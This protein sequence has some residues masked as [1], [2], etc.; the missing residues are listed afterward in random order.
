MDASAAEASA[1]SE[2]Q[3]DS[4]MSSQ[5]TDGSKPKKASLKRSKQ[6]KEKKQ[7]RARLS[8]PAYTV[9]QGEDM[10][11]VIS[12]S[13]S[14]Y[15]GS[16]WT[17]KKKG[18]KKKKIA[19]GKL[20]GNKTRP[21]KMIRAK[22]VVENKPDVPKQIATADSDHSWGQHLPEEVLINIFQLVVLQDGAVPFLCRVGRVCRLWN[23]AASSPVLWRRVT[24][25]HCWIAPGKSQ[26][27]NTERKVKQTVEWLAQNRFHQLRDF[28]L[29]HWTSHVD[30]TL[31]VV[32]K[33][34]P[35]LRSLKLSY[36][37]GLTSEA[38]QSLGQHS[39]QL[40]SLDLQYSEFKTEGLVEYLETHGSQIKQMLLTHELKN[41]K[42][43]TTIS[44]GCCPDLELLEVS[45]KLDSKDCDLPICI[46]ALQTACPKLKTFRMLN[47]RPMNKT[48]GATSSLSGFPLLEE[49]SMA[50]TSYSYV[51]DKFLWDMLSSS[52]HLR[53]LDLRGCARITPH[54]L[55]VLPCPELECLFW[56]Q[57]FSRHIGSSLPKKGLH[58]VTQKWSKTLRELD[59]ANQLFTEEDLD[60]AMSYL[61]QAADA[62]TLRSLNLSGTSITQP[63]I[64]SIVGEMTSLDYLNL[65]S[66]R[67][68]P[69]GAKR[70]YRGQEDIR[71]LL[72]ILE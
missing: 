41:N 31:Q 68:L 6:T 57:Y 50:T 15:V 70:I 32:S 44:K 5:R 33:F 16:V 61:A 2:R 63:T 18:S 52:T 48:R 43:W 34:C 65:S 51:T 17:R 20:K 21:K 22:P 59:V 11:F 10:L 39:R 54:G 55:A 19:K 40:Q 14:Q 28:S 25:G 8:K 29:C 9:H 42:L 38:F 23:A 72:D 71:Q 47:V 27:P 64:R 30:F 1:Q 35:Q 66:C 49:L 60:L 37:K 53:V 67:N 45:T 24:V 4:A 56:G 69:R 58:M 36:C 46:P 62:D 7:K 12:R 13:T 26:L 3:E